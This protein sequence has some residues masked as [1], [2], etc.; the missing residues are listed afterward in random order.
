M[1][2]TNTTIAEAEEMH[3]KALAAELAA[4]AKLKS[5]G[6][7]SPEVLTQGEP[8]KGE[9]EWLALKAARGERQRTLETLQRVQAAA[10]AAGRNAVALNNSM[11]QIERNSHREEKRP[12]E[13]TD[14]E[15]QPVLDPDALDERVIAGRQAITI[16]T[17]WVEA[18]RVAAAAAEEKFKKAIAA[19][20]LAEADFKTK[21]EPAW[22]AL[23][24][25]RDERAKFL[26]LLERAESELEQ[27]RATLERER[28]DAAV[29]ARHVRHE[30]LAA[31]HKKLVEQTLVP[32]QQLAC[33]LKQAERVHDEG[34]GGATSFKIFLQ[35]L[36]DELFAA[37][38]KARAQTVVL[39]TIGEN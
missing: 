32:L 36:N 7:V 37:T 10:E 25:A 31:E 2:E 4:E 38:R 18:K 27:T 15:G 35:K 21:G 8:F 39:R 6:G 30:R 24:A 28:A 29:T 26:A 14:E 3:A 23:A 16:V 33:I 13:A 9:R 34:G 17:G 1:S 20:K 11:M 5:M 19:L 12:V 22:P